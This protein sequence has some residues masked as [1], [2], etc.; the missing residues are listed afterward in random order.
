MPVDN[1]TLPAHLPKATELNTVLQA[2]AEQYSQIRRE[3][4]DSQGEAINAFLMASNRLAPSRSS[5]FATD[6]DM[7]WLLKNVN[8]RPSIDDNPGQI[9]CGNTSVRAAADAMATVLMDRLRVVVGFNGPTLDDT[10]KEKINGEHVLL[11]FREE[12][13]EM[14]KQLCQ[15]LRLREAVIQLNNA[16]AKYEEVARN[17]LSNNAE[18]RYTHSD[19][20]AQQQPI[21]K[22]CA[23]VTRYLG[24]DD[25]SQ[26]LRTTR[27]RLFTGL[28]AALTEVSNRVITPENLQTLS[29]EHAEREQPS[30]LMRMFCCCFLNQRR[31]LGEQAHGNTNGGYGA[32]RV[33]VINPLYHG[34]DLS[35]MSPP[36]PNTP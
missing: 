29:A 11:N 15:F 18:R 12:H 20:S 5:Q 27:G 34:E 22:I 23:E 7:A 2:I 16:V 19:F 26:S 24:A 4:V 13:S 3:M 1:K 10:D 8:S 31:G 6:I 32:A 33:E 28:S 30:W 35:V 25:A 14:V 9:T 21:F 17:F 36:P